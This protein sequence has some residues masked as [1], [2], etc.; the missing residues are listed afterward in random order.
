MK[1]ILYTLLFLPLFVTAQQQEPQVL[2]YV[3]GFDQNG[4]PAEILVVNIPIEVRQI[5]DMPTIPTNNNQLEND[6]RYLTTADESDPTVLT[7][8]KSITEEEKTS[9]GVAYTWGNH[10]G[11]YK[12]DS[13]VP[14]W[15]E[16]TSKPTLFSGSY[17][18]LTN[19]PT[20]PTNTNQLTNGSGF[21]TAEVDASTTNEIQTLSQTGS[22]VTLSN[23]GGSFTLPTVTDAQ[24]LGL[25]SN[26]LSISNGNSVALPTYP[27]QTLSQAGNVVTLSLAGGSFTL[28]SG[29]YP[30]LTNKP[31]IPTNTNQ[32][33]NGAGFLTTETDPTVSA[34]I[35]SITTTEKSN[36]NTAYNWGDHSSL[37]KLTS[38]VPTWSEITDKPTL[39]SGSYPDLTNK[40]TIPT[41]TNQLT[42][43]AE[44][45]TAEVDGSTTNELQTISIAGQTL[46]VS[47]GN[48]VT[49]P[50]LSI[51]APTA[52]IAFT[53]GT[54][55]QPRSGG[56]CSI[57]VQSSLSGIVGV[58][59]TV[60]VA[61]SS[62]Q[63][64]TYTT[65][66]LSSLLIAATGVVDNTNTGSVVVPS[67]Y[68]VKITTTATVGSVTSSYNRW[69][70]N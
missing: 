48:S 33:T 10:A 21:L 11:L 31:T 70:L 53:S 22:T 43:G 57:N 41:N 52:A 49:I 13:Y 47:S 25:S 65:V 59:G 35:K 36:W 4:K 8:I 63:G 50:S 26:T 15:T 19:K 56:N 34:H 7:H 2:H 23:S 12:L 17:P 32:L 1:K 60:T 30:D 46:S 40:P 62:T 38:Y 27:A 68:W 39:F 64:G 16:I 69:D 54:A 20:I 51:S 29:S 55:F 44:F 6:A 45:L 67:G 42:N 18:D 61:M 58:N 37:Y 3:M 66:G 5:S 9:W 14:T 24:T 28:F